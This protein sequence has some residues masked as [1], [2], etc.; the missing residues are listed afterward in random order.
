MVK[1]GAPKGF[2]VLFVSTLKRNGV[3]EPL[4]TVFERLPWQIDTPYSLSGTLFLFNGMQR[5][6]DHWPYCASSGVLVDRRANHRHN[7][8]LSLTNPPVDAAFNA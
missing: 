1:M 7:S 5:F 8:P 4:T 2:S 6:G 3:Y